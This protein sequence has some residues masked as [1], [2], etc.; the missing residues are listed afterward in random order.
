MK[1]EKQKTK[2]LLEELGGHFLAPLF[3]QFP[4][5]AGVADVRTL[6]GH[7]RNN[8]AGQHNHASLCSPAGCAAMRNQTCS[9]K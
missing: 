1:D 2:T 3:A 6:Q 5:S 9:T 8:R 4:G 7:L